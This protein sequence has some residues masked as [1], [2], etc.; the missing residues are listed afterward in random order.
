M[1]EN[2]ERNPAIFHRNCLEIQ[3][4][5]PISRGRYLGGLSHRPTDNPHKASSEKDAQTS[6]CYSTL[7]LKTED[8]QQLIK[9][10]SARCGPLPVSQ[11]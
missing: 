11:Q 7:H 6:F 9:M 3:S 5:M 2:S 4:E 1:T 10:N 8:I